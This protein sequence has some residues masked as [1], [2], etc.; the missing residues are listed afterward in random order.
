MAFSVFLIPITQAA[1]AQ[2]STLVNIGQEIREF[3]QSASE[4]LRNAWEKVDG[5]HQQRN[6]PFQPDRRECKP[7]SQQ[8]GSQR[9]P[10]AKQ[11]IDIDRQSVFI[12]IG[13]L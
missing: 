4:K 8:H 11:Y 9:H 1:N 12:D 6:H 3:T 13:Y 2:Q 10:I 5:P 7:R